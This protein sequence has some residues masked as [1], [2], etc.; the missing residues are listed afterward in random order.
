MTTT[1]TREN[2]LLP[3]TILLIGVV[4]PPLDTSVGP[5]DCSD[6]EWRALT[7]IFPFFT[8]MRFPLRAWNKNNTRSY[9]LLLSLQNRADDSCLLISP[10]LCRPSSSFYSPSLLLQQTGKLIASSLICPGIVCEMQML[11]SACKKGLLWDFSF[12]GGSAVF[13][14]WFCCLFCMI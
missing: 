5:Y 14:L 8:R 3:K 7:L 6:I 10:S 12:G 9:S 2:Q 4:I 13:E 1:G 11:L